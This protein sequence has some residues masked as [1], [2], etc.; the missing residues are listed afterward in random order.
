MPIIKVNN[1]NVYYE[2]QGMGE[3]LILIA[4][5]TCDHT[6][7]QPMVEELSHHFRVITL[8]NR[9]SGQTTDKNETLT[10]ELIAQD[11][12]ALI[13]ALQLE[14]PHIVGQSMG[15][16]IAQVV[17]SLYPEKIGKLGIITSSAK[18]RQATINGL[19]ASL[20][21]REKNL[22][23]D[24]IFDATIPWI[25]SEA[26]LKDEE[27]I[28]AFKQSIL[29]NPYPQSLRDQTRQFKALEIFEGRAGLKNIKAKT[30]I[31]YGKQDLISLPMEAEYMAN[32]I[33]QSTLV[34]FDCG[35]GITNELPEELTMELK[36]FFMN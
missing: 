15:G 29:D 21:M 18:W 22:D 36:H 1:A 34:S 35:H 33:L 28:A 25:F 10:T 32:Q 14:K 24:F 3:A 27:Q 19:K 16:T 12:L 31:V 26:F 4:G 8:D 11:V 20:T 23:F 6:V 2:S 9:G 30:L 7:W 17:A 13:E 5:Y